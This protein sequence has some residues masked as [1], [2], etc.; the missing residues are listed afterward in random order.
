MRAFAETGGIDLPP[1]ALAQIR[2]VFVGAGVSEAETTRA[3]VSTLNQTG[4]LVDPHTAVGLAAV[5]R[6][7]LGRGGAPLVVLS[8]AHAAKFAEAV[9][10]AAGVEP[11]LPRGARALAG[12]AERIDR[13]PADVEAV[14]TYIRDF[15]QV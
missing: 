11:D 10:A 14:K 8:T 12:K 6:L 5:Y 2:E 9:G 1:R 4:E 3:I 15:A 13:L 7:G